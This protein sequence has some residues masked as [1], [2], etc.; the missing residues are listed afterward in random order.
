MFTTT[1]RMPFSGFSKLKRQ[2]DEALLTNGGQPLEAWTFH[3]LRRSLVTG[4]NEEGVAPPH[5]IEAVVN[6]VSGL[7]GGIAGVYDRASYLEERRRALA[8]WA[9]L[10]GAPDATC[11]SLVSM[12]SVQ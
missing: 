8:A 4:L 3:D 6:H 9:N 5:I 2:L 12:R 11:G 7:R 1:C 10:I